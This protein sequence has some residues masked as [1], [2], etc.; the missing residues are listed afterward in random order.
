VLR[1]GSLPPQ[2]ES[3]VEIVPKNVAA[4]RP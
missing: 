4:E 2:D 3:A 1:S